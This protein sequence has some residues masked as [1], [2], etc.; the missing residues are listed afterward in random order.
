MKSEVNAITL[1]YVAKLGLIIKK[2]G[3]SIEKI[4]GSL[5]ITYET[6]LAGFLV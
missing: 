1:I 2:T 5:F 4:D 6:I 3:I